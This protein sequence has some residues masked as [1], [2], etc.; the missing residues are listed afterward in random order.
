MFVVSVRIFIVTFLFA[1]V[2]GCQQQGDTVPRSPDSVINVSNSVVTF[3]HLNDF[4]AHLTPH[5]NYA[6]DDD[7]W[8]VTE[9][10]GLARIANVIFAYV[11]VA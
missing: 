10:G 11:N 7:A 2:A 8:A 5:P 9:A 4:H 3:I 1:L 6:K